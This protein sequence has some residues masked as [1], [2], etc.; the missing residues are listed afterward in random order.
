MPDGSWY[1]KRVSRALRALSVSPVET[2]AVDAV[3]GPQR[4]ETLMALIESSTA[5]VLLESCEEQKAAAGAQAQ[6][7]LVLR[8]MDSETVLQRWEDS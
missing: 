4:R 2:K 8:W 7:E 5:Q 3:G 1:A 6:A